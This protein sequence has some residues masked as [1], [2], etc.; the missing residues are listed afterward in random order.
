MGLNIKRYPGQGICIYA[1]DKEIWIYA[2]EHQPPGQQI[3]LTIIA[4]TEMSIEREEKAD[5]PGPLHDPSRYLPR[6][7]HWG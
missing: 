7:K 5:R 3:S 6:K 4:P 2:S 1:G